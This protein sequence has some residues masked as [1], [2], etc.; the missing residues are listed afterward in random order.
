MVAGRTD[1]FS[2]HEDGSLVKSN[3]SEK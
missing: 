2:I 3:F 1:I